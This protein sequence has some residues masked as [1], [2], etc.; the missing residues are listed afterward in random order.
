M[1]RDITYKEY[2]KIND[3]HGTVLYPAVMVAPVQKDILSDVLDTSI[4]LKVFD[5]FHGSGTALYEAAE[6]SNNIHLYGCDINP[7]AN[8]ITRVKLQGVSDNIESNIAFIKDILSKNYHYDIHTFPNIHKWFRQDI[9]DDLSKLREAIIQIAN[10]ND[11]L[12]LWYMIIDI[13]R[14]Y[15]NTRSSTYKLHMKK[16]TDINNIRNNLIAD[17]ITSLDKNYYRFQKNYDNFTLLKCDTLAY[18]NNIGDN[19]FDICITSPPY[20]DNATTVTYG[21]FS[22]LPLYWID[23][24]DLVLE[25]WE[26]NNYSIIDSKSLGGPFQ[27]L[28]NM[29]ICFPE[30]SPYLQAIS[31]KKHKKVLRFFSGYFEFLDQ[32]SRVTGSFIIMTLGNRTVDGVK[33]NLTELTLK[34]LA[35]KGFTEIEVSKRDILS[36]RMPKKVSNVK[37]RPVSSMN[38]EYVIVMKK[39]VTSKSVF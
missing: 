5:P 4:Q 20:G 22:M 19:E 29:N 9:I 37:N 1:P 14:K 13:V 26:F 28:G 12:F 15:S 23:M 33:I 11:R 35:S 8:L 17:Y 32:I 34:R 38:E 25:G 10:K 24:K 3:I 18:L 39:T 7:L 21:Q 31:P 6:L 30:L 27:I 36:K 16:Q 2:K